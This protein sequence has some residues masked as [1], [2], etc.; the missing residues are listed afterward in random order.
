MAMQS[1]ALVRTQPPPPKKAAFDIDASSVAPNSAS[2][3]TEAF[4]GG[5]T[6]FESSGLRHL[7]GGSTWPGARALAR[8]RYESESP[9]SVLV[10]RPGRHC[11]QLVA[12]RAENLPAG[13]VEQFVAPT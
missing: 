13:Q 7:H 11:E 4:D 8:I 9:R 3:T 10:D 6:V 5:V 12:D 1:T 2:C